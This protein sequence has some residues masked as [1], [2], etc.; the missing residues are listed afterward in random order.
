MAP[1]LRCDQHNPESNTCGNDAAASD[2]DDGG[3]DDNDDDSGA[4]V[5][6]GPVH[7]SGH[8]QPN[9]HPSATQ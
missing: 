5:R 4:G 7:T 6:V 1:D 3:D 2:D 9:D 8:I